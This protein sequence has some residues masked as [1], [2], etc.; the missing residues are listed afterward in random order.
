MS[1]TGLLRLHNLAGKLLLE[2]PDSGSMYDKGT[3]LLLS[4]FQQSD[5][6]MMVSAMAWRRVATIIGS[7]LLV[8]ASLA[9]VQFAIVPFRLMFLLTIDDLNPLPS[10]VEEM[11]RGA[12]AGA[13]FAFGSILCF[14]GRQRGSQTTPR[15]RVNSIAR[16]SVVSL[17]IIAGG[18]IVFVATDTLSEFQRL[19]ARIDDSYETE[20]SDVT[21]DN[22]PSGECEGEIV[23]GVI[24]INE[25]IP[26][27]ELVHSTFDSSRSAAVVG[28]SILVFS[29]FLV[30]MVSCQSSFT[31]VD[32]QRAS[33]WILYCSCLFAS[34][35]VAMW[36]FDMRGFV[37]SIEAVY[38]GPTAS[39][40]AMRMLYKSQFVGVC[41]VLMGLILFLDR[42]RKKSLPST[43][44]SL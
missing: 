33:R 1:T 30:L 28:Y 9:L 15:R 20:D 31:G 10:M 18:S 43:P 21:E 38:S 17:M 42:F 13:G 5:Q 6:R 27:V 4:L 12:I 26:S 25:F 29:M 34:A 2:K 8:L 36:W 32:S 3:W 19:V 14:L 40:Y 39:D 11:R 24:V 37:N 41:L 35:H 7:A 22:N 16:V 23:G 44:E